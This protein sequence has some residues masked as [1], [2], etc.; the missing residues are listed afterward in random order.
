MSKNNKKN[1]ARKAAAKQRKGDKWVPESEWQKGKPK[2]NTKRGK[3]KKTKTQRKIKGG[4]NNNQDQPQNRSNFDAGKIVQRVEQKDID[5]QMQDS[6]SLQVMADTA[7]F[8]WWVLGTASYLLEKGILGALQPNDELGTPATI[9]L[10]GLNFITQGIG[11]VALGAQSPYKQIPKYINILSEGVKPKPAKFKTSQ[12]N[13]SYTGTNLGQ[14]LIPDNEVFTGYSY[15]FGDLPDDNETYLNLLDVVASPTSSEA[16]WN[17][18]L[19]EIVNK[20]L[21]MSKIVPESNGELT[22][23]DPSLYARSYVYNGFGVSPSG[24]WYA[25]AENECGFRSPWLSKFS[26]YN[27]SQLRAARTLW[28]SS[29]DANFAITSMLHP[30]F[31]YTD[32][33]TKN[34]PIFKVID[35]EEIY[36]YVCSWMVA[37][38]QAFGR[39]DTTGTGGVNYLRQSLPFTQQD[40][41]IC[42]RQALMVHFASSQKAVQFLGPMTVP[43]G[44]NGF[45]P[46]IAHCG[47]F[48][49]QKFGSL[50]LPEVLVENLH[51]LK[52]R[53]YNAGDGS[54]PIWYF[55]V[56]GRYVLDSVLPYQF[57]PSVGSAQNLFVTETQDSINL[58]DGSVTSGYCNLNSQYYQ[59]VC[60]VWN[61]YVGY[62][63][64]Y[65]GNISSL[66]GDHGPI[67]LNLLSCTRF[68]VTADVEV[69]AKGTTPEDYRRMFEEAAEKAELLKKLKR[70]SQKDIK[71]PKK[72]KPK[73]VAN[74]PAGIL[75]TLCTQ[76]YTSNVP[77]VTELST[78]FPHLILPSMRVDGSQTVSPTSLA[79]MQ[80]E[81]IEP[82]S[83]QSSQI[84]PDGVI[85]GVS[86][87]T[88]LQ[89]IG[90][91]IASGTAGAEN[92]DISAIMRMLKVK[93]QAG[94]LGDLAAGLV[95]G[96]FPPAAGVADAIAKQIPF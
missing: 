36:G 83:I 42:L 91:L 75:T 11:S 72:D 70:A 28:P 64:Q 4:K 46:F 54:N 35:F 23:S 33:G 79:M 78:I 12:V 51:C 93:G 45:V 19:P 3:N 34:P 58:I 40:F 47:T 6:M 67:G 59:D 52:A 32:L 39:Q 57:Q 8:K 49:L 90:N 10:N 82:R 21:P 89:A 71:I 44:A 74:L 69:A 87:S 37:C 38:Y 60:E 76:W 2:V 62:F 13:Y 29:G 31:V 7:S 5:P 16:P 25:D 94:F 80:I 17:T 96:I 68:E 66:S 24:G 48:G 50:M 30:D 41:R 65:G 63:E 18:L 14:G 20:T 26:Q 86:R 88:E 84:S 73:Q 95:G 1:A 15:V 53:K 81:S 61:Q 92:L 85:N 55:P 9:L 22:T 56:F 77:V 27:V 43:T